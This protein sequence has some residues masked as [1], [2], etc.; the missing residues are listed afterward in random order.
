MKQV[1]IITIYPR[2]FASNTYVITADGKNAIVIDPALPTV[3]QALAERGL[4]AQWVLLTHSHF[5]HIGGVPRL[6]LAGAKVGCAEKEKAAIGTLSEIGAQYG[7]PPF[8]LAVDRFF[9]DGE[10][11]ELCGVKLRV[12]ETPGHTVGSVCYL[13]ENERVIFSGDT[14]MPQSMGRTDFPTGNVGAMRNSLRKLVS[15]KGDYRVLS[16][17]G[18]ETTLNEE[19]QTNYFLA[20]L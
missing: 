9:R 17:H 14:L 15:L 3:A 19:R 5:D 6:A 12:M 20:E 4:S 18:E 13:L 16:G 1:E 8:D 11:L 2:G 7:Y 10:E